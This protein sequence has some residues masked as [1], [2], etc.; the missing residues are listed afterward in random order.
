MILSNGTGLGDCTDWIAQ[1][2]LQT[3]F[4]L[5]AKVDY[6]EV[7]L[8]AAALY[9]SHYDRDFRIPLEENRVAGTKPPMLTDFAGTYLMENLDIVR[10]GVDVD[11]KNATKLRMTVNKQP[12][13]VWEMWHYNFDVFCHLPETHDACLT[14]GLDRT[15]WSS[16]LICFIRNDGVVTRC[17]WKLDGVDVFFVRS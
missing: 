13:Q 9:L 14:R 2:M 7:A 17:S 5:E 4:Q 16:F 12:D 1:D 11:P 10:L 3:M 15:S 6:I 8:R